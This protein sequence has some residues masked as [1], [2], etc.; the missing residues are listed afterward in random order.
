MEAGKPAGTQTNRGNRMSLITLADALEWCNEVQTYFVI[1]ADNDEL[2]FTSSSGGPVTIDVT[3]GTYE[4]AAL[5]TLLTTLMNASTTLTGTGHVTFTVTYSSTTRKFTIAA[6]TPHTIA[7]THTGSD[8]GLTF[9]FNAAHTA[10]LSI[11]SDVPAGDPSARVQQILDL[12]DGWTKRIALGYS[13][14]AADYVEYHDGGK[15]IIFLKEYPVITIKRVTTSTRNGIEIKNTSTDMAY[16]TVSISSTAMT[17]VVVGGAN[18]GTSTVTFA[19][20]D[21]LGEIVTAIVALGAGWTAELSDSTF[22][23]YPYTELI[24]TPGIRLSSGLTYYLP[25]PEDEDIFYILNPDTGQLYAGQGAREIG[26]RGQ[27]EE[28]EVCWPRGIRNVR[29]EFRGGH[30]TVPAILQTGLG[31]LVKAMYQ[32]DQEDAGGVQTWSTAGI[33]KAYETLPPDVKKAFDS[34]AHK[35]RGIW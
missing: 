27:V 22:T 8:A 33:S 14:E 35:S 12:A 17:L 6:D 29:V 3:D 16:A 19:T 1:T 20:Y 7:Y 2:I 4:G 18:A 25:I 21:D 26:M 10:A 23:D 5:A 32:R 13:V 30:E 11:T 31:M 15:P 24:Q 34:Y 9:G 28:Y